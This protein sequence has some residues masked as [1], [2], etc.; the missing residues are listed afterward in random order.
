[1][2]DLLPSKHKLQQQKHEYWSLIN[3]WLIYQ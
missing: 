2:S 1:M 3:I